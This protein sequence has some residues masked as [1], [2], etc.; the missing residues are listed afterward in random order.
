L[1]STNIFCQTRNVVFKII[2]DQLMPVYM[3]FILETSD[4]IVKIAGS[5]DGEFVMELPVAFDTFTISSVGIEQKSIILPADCHRLELVVFE[6]G[7]YDFMSPA[8]VDRLERRRFNTLPNLHERAFMKGVFLN[9]N[10]CHRERF[11]SFKAE[12]K[13]IHKLRRQTSD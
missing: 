1:I 3:P 9:K 4:T 7:T 13:R 12:L 10:P 6:S 11:I 8:K 5:P 2:D